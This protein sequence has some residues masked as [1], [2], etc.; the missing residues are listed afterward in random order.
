MLAGSPSPGLGRQ[1]IGSSSVRNASYQ[2][3]IPP[4]PEPPSAVGQRKPGSRY[5]RITT[6]SYRTGPTIRGLTVGHS[7]TGPLPQVVAVSRASIRLSNPR[8]DGYT[9]PGQPA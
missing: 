6:A 9:A 7:V 1:V 4:L 8:H 3:M 2:V 5:I